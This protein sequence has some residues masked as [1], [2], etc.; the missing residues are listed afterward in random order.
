MARYTRFI[1]CGLPYRGPEHLR[2][3][4]GV[5]QYQRIGQ[6]PVVLEFLGLL[7]GLASGMV[8]S[9]PKNSRASLLDRHS[10]FAAH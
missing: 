1:V 4:N 9:L 8:P 6:D 7:L 5:L 2:E 3:V 10:F